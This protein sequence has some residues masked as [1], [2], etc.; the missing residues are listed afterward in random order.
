LAATLVVEGSEELVIATA[1]AQV[2]RT[3]LSEVGV[4]GRYARGVWVMRP[5]E[6][7]YITS[8]AILT[9]SVGDSPEPSIPPKPA[10]KSG[11]KTGKAETTDEARESGQAQLA[12]DI[13]EAAAGAEDLGAKD[14][15][16]PEDVEEELEDD[17]EEDEES[18]D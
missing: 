14:D 1:K 7:D 16:L 17:A 10:G 11:G 8:V 6:G 2:H 4:Q 9:P 18:E 13:E 15:E 3:R 5:A 12:M